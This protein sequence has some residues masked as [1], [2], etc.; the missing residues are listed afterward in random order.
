MRLD[1]NMIISIKDSFKLFGISIIMCCAVCVCSLFLNYKVDL[2]SIHSQI[3]T[4]EG[5]AM[6]DALN[7][8]SIVVCICSGG[9]LAITSVIML[10]FYIKL[11]IDNHS[12]DIGIFKALGYSDFKIARGFSIFGLSVF[13]GCLAGYLLGLAL[14]PT[15]YNLQNS[16]NLIPDVPMNIHWYLVLLLVVVPTLV[17]GL[18]AVFYALIKLRQP[19]NDL[20]RG[21]SKTKGKNVDFKEKKNF[22]SDMKSSN[23]RSRKTLVFFIGLSAFCFS[24]MIQMSTSMID[25]ASEMMMLM[26]LIIGIVLGFTTLY[27]AVT[28]VIH[29]NQKNIA[30]LRVFGYNF[31]ECKKAVLDGYRLS[32][33]IGFAIGTVYQY[34]L[35]K[36]M[37]TVVF[38]DIVG[39]PEYHF[40]WL[41]FVITLAA[42]IVVYEGIMFIYGYMMKKISLKQIMIE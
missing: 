25:L 1:G 14:M 2:A 36:I 19:C 12:K 31:Y 40:D 22:L 39:V 41:M 5:H 17:F 28:T 29:S 10:F 6:Y 7:S 32:A 16:G 34:V 4:P 8:T 35:L 3:T 24:A 38:K 20:L 13:I 26:I 27:I 30:M 42:F 11:Y 9:C 37:V 21:I 33:Y 15:Y 23:L 18:I